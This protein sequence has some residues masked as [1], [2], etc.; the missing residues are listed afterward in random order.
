VPRVGV[1]GYVN[2]VSLVDRDRLWCN[3]CATVGM[4]LLPLLPMR[5]L[6]PLRPLPLIMRNGD[7]EDDDIDD[8]DDDGDDDGA[9]HAGDT[10]FQHGT[11]IV[12]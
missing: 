3:E 12:Q 2:S 1:S 8:D 4:P 10:S 7:D 5:A 11:H 6:A 9:A